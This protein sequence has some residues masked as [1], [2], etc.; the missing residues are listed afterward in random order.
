MTDVPPTPVAML[1]KARR[2]GLDA[3]LEYV[4]TGN[5]PGADGESTVCPKC[6]KIVIGRHG[7][8][9]TDNNLENGVCRFCRSPIVGIW[10]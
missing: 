3:G 2:F 6:E 1:E 8:R 4:Y 10:Q 7:F 9:L 5:I